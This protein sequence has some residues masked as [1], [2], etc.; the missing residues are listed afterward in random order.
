LASCFLLQEE[1][2]ATT[3]GEV[4]PAPTLGVPGFVSSRDNGVAGSPGVG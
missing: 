2:E 1:P 3:L 4:A